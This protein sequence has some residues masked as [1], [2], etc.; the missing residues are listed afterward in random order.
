MLLR[1]PDNVDALR[2]LAGVAMRA[3]QWGDAQT[4]LD[5]ALELAPD[6]F[7][8][9]M[10]LGLAKQEQDDIEGAVAAYKRAIRL[11]TMDSGSIAATLFRRGGE[12]VSSTDGEISKAGFAEWLLDQLE[13]VID[14]SARSHA[15]RTS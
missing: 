12:A 8:G 5:R 13:P 9:W 6:F 11:E 10:D 1:D 15:D 2:L 7:Q 4:L 14:E 3:K